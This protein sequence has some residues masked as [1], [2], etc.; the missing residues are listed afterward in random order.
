M[1]ATLCK[2]GSSVDLSARRTERL[3]GLAASLPCETR[4]LTID[5][6][7]RSSVEEAWSSLPKDWQTVDVLINNAGLA[8]GLEPIHQGDPNDWDRVIDTNIKGILYL[9]H[10]VLPSMLE[11]QRGHLVFLGSTSSHRTYA[12]GAVY[13]ASKHALNAIVRSLKQ[14]LHGTPLR[15][16]SIDPGMVS[17]T[18]FS[19]VRFR[20]DQQRAQKVYQDVPSPLQADDIADIIAFVVTRPAHVN[21]ADVLVLPTEQ[22]GLT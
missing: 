12:G 7:L 19:T 22:M 18:E 15:V 11:R 21:I 10:V 20:G 16:S 1:C 3:E 4:I 14:E 2:D 13:C 8:L 5:V 6:R 17:D 9:S